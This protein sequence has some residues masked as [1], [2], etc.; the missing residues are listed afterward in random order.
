MHGYN[1]ER[2]HVS[3]GYFIAINKWAKIS[4]TLPTRQRSNCKASAIIN[5]LYIIQF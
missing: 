2:L 1:T 5:G 4:L 3:L